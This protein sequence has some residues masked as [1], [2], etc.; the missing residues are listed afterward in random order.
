MR[1]KSMSL[2]NRKVHGCSEIRITSGE[3]ATLL[4][5]YGFTGRDL[6]KPVKSLPDP[7]PEKHEQNQYDWMV[8][9]GGRGFVHEG[10]H[11]T[12][13]SPEEREFY[14][15]KMEALEKEGVKSW[16]YRYRLALE[17]LEEWR[18]FDYVPL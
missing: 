16:N 11:T 8:V 18:K 10:V 1:L 6:S 12:F 3:Y 5:Q 9:E 14:L 15:E 4:K 2:H 7:L 13:N 17:A